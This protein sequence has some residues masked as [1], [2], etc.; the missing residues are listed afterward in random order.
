MNQYTG[1]Y[2]RCELWFIRRELEQFGLQPLEGK[3]I[4]FLQDNQCTQEDIGAHFDLDKGRIARSLSELEEKGLVRRLI[5]EKNKRQKFVSLTVRGNQVLEEIHRI[6]GRWDEICFAGF[7]EE[8]TMY[9]IRAKARDNA[10]TPMQ[11]NAEK[12]AGF[13]E[14]TPWYR[15]NPN[16]K[17][18]NVEQALADPESVFYHYQKLIQ[19]RKEHEVMV[20]GTYQLLFPEDED[21]YI[22]TRTLEEEKWLIICNFIVL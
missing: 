20:Y 11:W 16:Y 18:I 5:N 4:M 13:T 17:E 8:E 2:R 21:L 9:A 12:N 19:L 22:Y 6:S 3:I 7:T 1:I 10:R 14:G 15:V